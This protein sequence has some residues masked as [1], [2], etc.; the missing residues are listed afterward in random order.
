M[1]GLNDQHIAHVEVAKMGR[2]RAGHEKGDGNYVLSRAPD[3]ILLGN[4][5]V[6]PFPLDEKSMAKK[7]ILKSEHEL[8]ANPEFHKNYELHCVRLGGGGAFQYFTFF[9]KKNLSTANTI[10]VKNNGGGMK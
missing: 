1:L 9:Q 5:A 6:L 3:Y 2:G 8:W 10:A 7:L 4:V